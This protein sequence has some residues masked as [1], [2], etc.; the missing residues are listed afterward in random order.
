MSE[1]LKKWWAG[2]AWAVAIFELAAGA[3]VA[4]LASDES[5][6]GR[7]RWSSLMIVGGALMLWGLRSRLLKPRRGSA[8]VAL[9]A[10]AGPPLVLVRR[11]RCRGGRR[12][13]RSRSGAAER[14][15]AGSRTPPHMSAT[16][17][18]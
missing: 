15:G 2:L 5:I 10:A 3:Q 13:G 1:K 9:G 6:G 11:A 4:V 7:I 16:V 12:A 18:R 17:G 8:L 14:S